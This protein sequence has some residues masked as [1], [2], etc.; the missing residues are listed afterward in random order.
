MLRTP[1]KHVVTIN[2]VAGQREQQKFLLLAFNHG[3]E[4]GPEFDYEIA[5]EKV[6]KSV[7]AGFSSAYA[8]E[9][10]KAFVKAAREQ[11]SSASTISDPQ[12]V[13]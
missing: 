8:L 7:R 3:S 13:H 10:A 4:N 2:L 6:I 11:L 9:E 1:P 5:E 12:P